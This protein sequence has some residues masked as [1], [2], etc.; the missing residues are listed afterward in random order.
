MTLITA[1]DKFVPI[2]KT[3]PWPDSSGKYMILLCRKLVLQTVNILRL[4]N[5]QLSFNTAY[6]FLQ[7]PA[8]DSSG[9][10][11][12]LGTN[13][14]AAV[15]STVTGKKVSVKSFCLAGS[16]EEKFVFS[17]ELKIK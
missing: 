1:P 14:P 12:F 11:I 3:C 7:S 15:I 9:G 5:L 4:Y 2:S 16:G 6:L 13:L 17:I 10:H 8:R